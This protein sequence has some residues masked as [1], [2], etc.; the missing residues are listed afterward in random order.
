MRNLCMVFVIA[1]LAS[2][3]GAATVDSYFAGYS[4]FSAGNDL[5]INGGD[6]FNVDSGWFRND[7]SHIGGNPNYLAGSC[8][9]CDGYFHD[10]FSFNLPEVSEITSASFTVYT[11]EMGADAGTFL[12]YGSS[13][14]PA[15]VLSGTDWNDIGKYDAL[16][17]GPLVGFISLTPANSN[18][19]VTATFNADG[20]AWLTTHAGGSVVLGGDFSQVVPEPG[21]LL[22]LAL[23]TGII[24]LA[25]AIRRVRG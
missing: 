19:W 1:L 17:S 20:I 18:S 14:L 3:A 15:G 24:S 5:V 8:I 7:G 12:M 10:Y 23:G 16:I 6:H 22:L 13:L 4:G 25:G 9:G 11:Y 2:T 21:S